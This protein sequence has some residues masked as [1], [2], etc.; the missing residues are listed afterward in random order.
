METNCRHTS[1]QYSVKSSQHPIKQNFHAF[2]KWSP[3][4]YTNVHHLYKLICT[5]QMD[6]PEVMTDLN[7]KGMVNCIRLVL[8]MLYSV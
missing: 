1:I 2:Y 3:R 5:I 4:R 7:C 6:S 8:N